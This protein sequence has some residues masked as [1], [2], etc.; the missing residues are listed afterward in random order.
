MVLVVTLVVL[1]ALSAATWIAVLV[2]AADR[3][4]DLGDRVSGLAPAFAQQLL[5]RLEMA[6]ALVQ[7]LSAADAGDGDSVLRQ[8]VVASD[9]FEFHR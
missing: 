2:I 6:N 3:D 4:A 8:R 7:Y 9:T 1:V 5:S